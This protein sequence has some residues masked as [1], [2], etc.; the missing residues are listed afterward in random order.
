MAWQRNLF[1]SAPP[2]QPLVVA[3]GL[4]VDS[5]AM[6]IGLKQRG[7][8]PDLILFADTGGEKPDTYL[9]APIFRQWL[10]DADFPQFEVVRYEPPIA[11]YDSLYGNCW[12]NETLPSLAFGRKAC[13]IKWKR[14]P[15]DKYVRRW[16]P[17]RHTG[18]A[19]VR[20]CRSTQG[21]PA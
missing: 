8:R 9:Y 19:I 17:D 11:E 15:Q 10:R 6:L 14:A 1:S 18:D 21:S 7:V 4:G 13:S 5:T 2:R 20:G 12:Q 16:A 3:Y